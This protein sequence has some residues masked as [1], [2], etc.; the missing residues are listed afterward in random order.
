M[1]NVLP[2][3]IEEDQLANNNSRQIQTID[4]TNLGQN[5]E[6]AMTRGGETTDMSDPDDPDTTK[7]QAFY[8]KRIKIMDDPFLKDGDG[9]GS[10]E[11]K[12]LMMKYL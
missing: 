4:N 8:S 5:L 7:T 1:E 9:S 11:V 10:D 12:D 2:D 3:L 6:N